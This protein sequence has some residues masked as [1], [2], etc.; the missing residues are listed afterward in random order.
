MIVVFSLSTTMRLARPSWLDGHVFE[1]KTN[2]FG[3][4]LPAGQDRDILQHGLAP[5]AEARRLHG[6]AL[7]AAA[8]VI[9]DQRRQRF[10]FD[11]FGHH[12]Q[13][14]SG[15]YDFIEQAAAGP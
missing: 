8:N 1:L 4:D 6:A 12:Q 9:D 2:I 14:A 3:N 10:A 11:I 7:E 5:I 15:F 13:R